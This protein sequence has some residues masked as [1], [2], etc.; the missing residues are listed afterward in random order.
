MITMTSNAVSNVKEILHGEEKKDWGL[1]IG[2]KQGGCS[3][4]SYEMGLDEKPDVSDVVVEMEGLKLFVN[5]SYKDLLAGI[6]LDFVDDLSGQGFKFNNPNAVRS[7]G[8]GK[9]FDA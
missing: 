7:C 5:E 9:S 8:C 4:F 3:G 1:R 2:L 6:E